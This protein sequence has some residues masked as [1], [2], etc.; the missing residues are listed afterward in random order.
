MAE[1]FVQT[2]SAIVSDLAELDHEDA[3]V[4]KNGMH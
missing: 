4:R 2:T 3:P 1:V